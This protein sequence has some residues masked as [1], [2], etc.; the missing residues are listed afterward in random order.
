MLLSHSDSVDL[1]LL[2]DIR[3]EFIDK[4]VFFQYLE[5]HLVKFQL[6]RSKYFYSGL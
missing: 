4:N 2:M 3:G 1:T 6:H 5:L